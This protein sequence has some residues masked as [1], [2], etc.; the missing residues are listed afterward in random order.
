M[1]KKSNTTGV[2]CGVNPAYLPGATEFTC[3][4]QN[5]EHLE[6]PDNTMAKR[7]RKNNDI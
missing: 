2:T 7:K 3:F 1:F 5:S 4:R 6:R